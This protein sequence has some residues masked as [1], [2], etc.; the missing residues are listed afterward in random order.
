MPGPRGAC[1]WRRRAS[2]GSPSS[3]LRKAVRLAWICSSSPVLTGGGQRVLRGVLQHAVI[4]QPVRGARMQ[5]LLL[6]R[7]QLLQA[8]AQGFV[9]QRVHAQPVGLFGR[10][11]HGRVAH[12]ALQPAAVVAFRRQCAAQVRVQGIG[13]RNTGQE[14]QVL[15]VQAAQQVCQHLRAQA[16]A[17]RCHARQSR[18]VAG[19]GGDGQRELQ[20]QRPAFGQFVQARDFVAVDPVAEAV[21]HQLD[22][23]V[24]REAQPRRA[25]R[26]AI[27]V[28]HQVFQLQLAIGSGGNDAVQ[29]GRDVAQ[30]VGQG[31]ARGARQPVGFVDDQHQVQRALRHF[32]QPAGHA[33]QP[34]RAARLQQRVAEGGPP[35]AHAHGQGQALHEAGGIVLRLRQQ[36][37]DGG[38]VRQVVA[39]QLR[40]HGRLAEAGRRLHHHHRGRAQRRIATQAGARDHVARQAGRRDLQQQV[41]GG[42]DGAGGH[43]GGAK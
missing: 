2:A 7:G 5:G 38:P 32:R 31:L 8:L 11:E 34:G 12:Q 22:G 13:H 33:F 1:C 3:R 35:R 36:P 30:Q 25:D 16:A 39:P 24:Q 43:G 10:D 19:G 26:Q 9:R 20:A 14:V 40:Q 28:G 15:G 21:A 27:A 4:G 18:A 29:V 42:R 23:L 6:S 41:A 37:G 17:M